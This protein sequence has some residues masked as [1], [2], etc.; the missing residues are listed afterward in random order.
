MLALKFNLSGEIACFS[1]LLLGRL[2][3]RGVRSRRRSSSVAHKC[4]TLSTRFRFDIVISVPLY[5]PAGL[6]QRCHFNAVVWHAAFF[7]TQLIV[8]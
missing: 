1:C 5:T 6:S 2:F 4:L 7:G 8:A 3:E